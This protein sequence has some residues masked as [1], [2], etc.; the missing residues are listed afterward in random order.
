MSVQVSSES[1]CGGECR[2][3]FDGPLTLDQSR[4]LEDRVFD[5]LRRYRRF[6]VDLSGVSEIDASGAHLLLTFLHLGGDGVRLARI[7][8]LVRRAL[9][10]TVLSPFVT[11]SGTGL[12]GGPRS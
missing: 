2:M 9:P 6:R 11:P 10:E 4:Q 8:E 1:T 3:V 5:A 12:G 7:N